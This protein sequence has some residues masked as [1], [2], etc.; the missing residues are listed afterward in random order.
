MT[1]LR[2]A[3][4]GDW[5]RAPENS[6]P[7]M[8]AALRLPTCDGLEF[9]VRYALDGVPIVLH[10]PTLARV[11]GIAIDAADLTTTELGALGVPTLESVLIAAGPAAFL[12]IE[13]KE[14][15]NATCLNLIEGA[16]GVADGGLRRVVVS[17]FE[18]AI[19]RALAEAR[20]GWPRWLNSHVLSPATVAR[21]ADLGCV[22]ISAE[23]H[24]IDPRSAEWTLGAGLALA[25]FTVR[26]RATFERLSGLGVGAMCVEGTALDA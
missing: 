25:A 12:D 15:P 2:L 3:H 18:A 8:V 1:A 24:A 10:D 6:L 17:S 7:A 23:W 19:I 22:G 14:P 13:L 9:D 21:A 4:R 5:R 20:P 26:R 11:Q 16:R